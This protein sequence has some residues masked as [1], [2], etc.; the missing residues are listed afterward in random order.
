[1]E[2]KKEK[3]SKNP[4]PM[5]ILHKDDEETCEC[6]VCCPLKYLVGI[7][8]THSKNVR[9]EDIKCTKHNRACVYDQESG[10]YVLKG[11]K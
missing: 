5:D 2:G 9:I 4:F 8:E 10:W 1:M 11:D 7:G 6:P 3:M